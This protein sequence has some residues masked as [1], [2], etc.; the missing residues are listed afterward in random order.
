MKGIYIY[1]HTLL[2]L[3]AESDSKHTYN[4]YIN[5]VAFIIQFIN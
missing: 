4:T 2:S 1:T 5:K 3:S